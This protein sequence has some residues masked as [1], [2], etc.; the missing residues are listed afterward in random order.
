MTGKDA[1]FRP[2]RHLHFLAQARDSHIGRLEGDENDW[3][4]RVLDNVKRLIELRK[5]HSALGVNDTTWLH[6]DFTPGRR[7]MVW[8]RGSDDNPVIVVAKSRI[9]RQRI[10]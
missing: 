9:F 2:A 4:R 3:R 7:V 8:Q 5:T 1:D 6:M 10:R